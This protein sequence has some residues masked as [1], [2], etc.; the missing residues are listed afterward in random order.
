MSKKIVVSL[1]PGDIKTIL[2][3]LEERKWFIDGNK[4]KSDSDK[5]HA[6][7]Y[8]ESIIERIKEGKA[9]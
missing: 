1:E 4:L 6:I 2:E 8:I 5:M 3:L 7:L 9:Q